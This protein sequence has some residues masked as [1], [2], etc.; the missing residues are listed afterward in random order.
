MEK[1]KKSRPKKYR[2]KVVVKWPV[3]ILVTV[4][5]MMMSSMI[6]TSIK[7]AMPQDI[8]LDF[9]DFMKKAEAGEIE[10]VLIIKGNPTFNATLDDGKTYTVVN[11]DSENFRRELLEMGVKIDIRKTTLDAAVSSVM[12]TIPMSALMIMLVVFICK[13]MMAESTTLFKLLRDGGKITFDNVAGMSETKEEV[14]TV[15]EGL[16]NY[17]ELA[18]KGAKPC[19]G[20]ILEGPPGTGKTLIAK[21]IA[22]EAGVPFISTSG[23]DFVEMFVGL[24]AARVR[25]LWRLAVTNAPCVV[26]IDEIDA[27]GRR[28]QSANSGAQ[29]ENNQTLNALLQ[30]MDGLETKLGI[31]VIGAT[32]MVD[33]LD[34]ALLRPG[35]FDKKIHIGPP[36]TKKDREEIIDVHLRGKKLEEGLSA[37][38]FSRLMFGLTGA[39]IEQA[40]NEAVIISMENGRN[41]VIDIKSVDEAVMKGMSG[42]VKLRTSAEEDLKVTSVHEAGH[43]VMMKHYGRKVRKVSIV[44]Y[45]SG[46]GGVT[47]QDGDEYDSHKFKSRR[48]FEEEI[49]IAL[50]GLAAERLVKGDGYNGAGSDLR[51]ATEML[52]QMFG[53]LGM[54]ENLISIKGLSELSG[55][56]I[57]SEQY[58]KQLIDECNAYLKERMKHVTDILRENREDLDDL[59]S[60]LLEEEVV[61]DWYVD[62]ESIADETEQ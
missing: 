32:N 39:E 2:R 53:T 10:S 35:R 23:S 41:G 25:G 19:K 54:G 1:E 11:P 38:S 12:Y 44:P 49:D 36:K 55:F 8:D 58:S 37:A 45:S 13:Q 6:R 40:L 30:K 22:G 7:D 34:P 18:K 17:K 26:F 15:V 28:R 51:K 3:I 47:M 56:G 24:G 33:D 46:V 60:R 9:N 42:G 43:A 59:S 5:L 21:A 27:V 48:E 57:I 20:I 52:M 50:G 29:M 62:S 4:M 61:V 14:M 16:K 31:L